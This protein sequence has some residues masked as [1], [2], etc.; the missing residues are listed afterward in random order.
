MGK[1]IYV[2]PVVVIASV[3]AS[4]VEAFVILPAHLSEW[5]GLGARRGKAPAPWRGRIRS[6]LDG[7]IRAVIQRAYRPM[8]EWL[9]RR[10]WVVL[11]GSAC[12]LLVV[13]GLVAGGR[14]PFVMFPKFDGNSIRARIQFPE[15]APAES[16][17]KMMDRLEASAWALNRC[18]R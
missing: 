18:R 14:T 9:M 10:R 5:K 17:Q 12:A 3:A 4:L 1:L 11:S 7:Y 6:R 15:G 8:I 2:L 16:A 13:A